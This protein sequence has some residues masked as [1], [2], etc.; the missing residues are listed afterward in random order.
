[1]RRLP[2]AL[3]EI[4]LRIRIFWHASKRDL[5]RGRRVFRLDG[6]ALEVPAERAWAYADGAY[7]E[8]NVLHWLRRAAA[9]IERPVFYD[10]GANCGQYAVALA[11]AARSVYA[12]EP[13]GAIYAVLERNI[14]RNG[15]ANVT[16]LPLALGAE[17][18]RATFFL[19]SSSGLSGAIERDERPEGEEEVEVATV[20]GLLEAGELLPPDIVKI[21]TEGTELFVL[22]GARNTIREFAPILVLEFDPEKAQAAGYS[23]A[24]LRAELAGCSYEVFGLSD[25]FTGD[26][27]DTRLHPLEGDPEQIANL[28]A[29]PPGRVL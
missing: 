7:Y 11:S 10:V 19:Y 16:P 13:I 26:A 14:A 6:A 8:K 21:D 18:G 15:L 20:D 9:A 3:G 1:L 2:Q 22:Q 25:P 24:E 23:L 29:I 4:R 17:R 12:F 28:I 27:R 5:I